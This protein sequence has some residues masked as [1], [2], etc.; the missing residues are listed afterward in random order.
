MADAKTEADQITD[1]MKSFRDEHLEN[2]AQEQASPLSSLVFT[3]TLTAYRRIRSHTL[4]IAQA[5]TRE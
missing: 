5:L 1:S 2:V 3:D 4:N